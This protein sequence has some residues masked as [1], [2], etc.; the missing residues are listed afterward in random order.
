MERLEIYNEREKKSYEIDLKPDNS[1]S[2]QLKSNLFSPIDKITLNHSF[3]ITAP[4]T[5]QNRRAFGVGN[6]VAADSDQM[7]MK[8]PCRFYRN[9]VLL[10]NGTCHIQSIESGSFSLLLVWGLD[11]LEALKD[12]GDLEELDLGT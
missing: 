2:L 4:D 11:C 1:V 6:Q 12:G 7:R 8:F 3:T 9:G 5:L 10:F